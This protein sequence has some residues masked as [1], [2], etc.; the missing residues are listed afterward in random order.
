MKKVD[1]WSQMAKVQECLIS[2]ASQLGERE[3]IQQEGSILER[4]AKNGVATNK[5]SDIVAERAEQLQK[6]DQVT[7]FKESGCTY[8]GKVISI[9]FSIPTHSR[10]T[11]TELVFNYDDHGNLEKA[12]IRLAQRSGERSSVELER[13]EALLMEE[14]FG[15]RKRLMSDPIKEDS[16]S[17][18]SNSPRAY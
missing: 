5:L 18:E 1:A 3:A 12:Y 14:G 9:T 17:M 15:V 7:R 13:K 10:D 16:L 8:Q 6:L 2:I 11:I 4:A